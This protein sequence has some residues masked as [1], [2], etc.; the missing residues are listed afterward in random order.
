VIFSS[1]EA[2]ALSS[3]IAVN[4]QERFLVAGAQI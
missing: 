2:V 1:F 4:A 3:G